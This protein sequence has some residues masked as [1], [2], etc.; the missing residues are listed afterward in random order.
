MHNGMLL[1]SEGK[2]LTLPSNDRLIAFEE[3]EGRYTVFV[4]LA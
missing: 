3:I 2:A 1:L 4:C